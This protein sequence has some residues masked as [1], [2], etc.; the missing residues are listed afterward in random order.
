VG[1]GA[2]Q[3]ILGTPEAL[4]RVARGAK[5]PRVMGTHGVIYPGRGCS[6]RNLRTPPGCGFKIDTAFPGCVLRT[7][8]GYRLQRL[9]RKGRGLGTLQTQPRYLVSYG[10]GGFWFAGW[11]HPAFRFVRGR[12]NLR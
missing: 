8:R 2:I 12:K 3:C 10:W 4:K 6:F 9:R 7:T 11:G 1:A 5:Q